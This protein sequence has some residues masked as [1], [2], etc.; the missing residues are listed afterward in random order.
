MTYKNG[1]YIQ[2]ACFCEMAI[3]EASGVFSLIRI[4]DTIVRTTQGHNPP[5]TN[6]R[7]TYG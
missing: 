3:Q 4:V 7:Q 6:V 1:P 5:T 2:A